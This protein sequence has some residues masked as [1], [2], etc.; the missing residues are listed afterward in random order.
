[1]SHPHYKIPFRAD[2]LFEGKDMPTC[3]LGE[4]IAQHIQLLI[5]TRFG[6][7]R[8]DY[9]YGNGIWQMEFER[10]VS[11]AR[12]EE[13]F[14][15]SVIKA[16]SEYEARLTDVDAELKIEMVEKVYPMKKFTEVK[17]KVIIL[18]RGKLT[19]TGE[20]FTFRTELYLSPMSID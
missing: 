11:E 12:W 5:T 10:A 19:E 17:K 1:M 8:F 6:E 16:V 13:S 3:D 20:P 9:D 4:S 18:V 2:L 15:Q 7:H 14:R